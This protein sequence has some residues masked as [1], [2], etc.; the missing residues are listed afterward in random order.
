MWL[1][2]FLGEGDL[3]PSGGWGWRAWGL[4]ARMLGLGWDPLGVSALSMPIL[5]G[6]LIL[7]GFFPAEDNSLPV[8][9]CN[10]GAEPRALMV[11][12]PASWVECTSYPQARR[13]DAGSGWAF[14]VPLFDL[15]R[16]ELGEGLDNEPPLP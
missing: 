5:C 2:S 1:A 3:A 13:G 7:C 16:P 14:V 8:P 9:A 12:A 10:W 11:W 15:C 4:G 6:F